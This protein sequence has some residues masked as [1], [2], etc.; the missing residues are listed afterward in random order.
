MQD[1]NPS[2]GEAR[3]VAVLTAIREEIRQHRL[4]VAALDANARAS[5]EHLSS[6]CELLAGNID[7]LDR[8]AKKLGRV[9]EAVEATMAD[10]DPDSD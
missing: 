5:V 7:R 8:I 6:A 4:G 9:L 3:T 10:E 1:G 2:H